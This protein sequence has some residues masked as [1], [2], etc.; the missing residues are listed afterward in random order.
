MGVKEEVYYYGNRLAVDIPPAILPDE[1][2]VP[3][4]TRMLYP[5]ILERYTYVYGG[6]GPTPEESVGAAISAAAHRRYRVGVWVPRRWVE[7]YGFPTDLKLIRIYNPV[8]NEWIDV[9]ERP[10][11]TLVPYGEGRWRTEIPIDIVRKYNMYAFPTRH[12]DYPEYAM[13][14]QLQWT[15]YTRVLIPKKPV[16]YHFHRHYEPE[17]NREK[18]RWTWI[19][20]DDVANDE[21]LYIAMEMAGSPEAARRLSS[22]RPDAEMHY[23]NGVVELQFLIPRAWDKSVASRLGKAYR[24]MVVRNYTLREEVKMEEEVTY[25][26]LIEIRATLI[27]TPPRE[28]YQG[29]GRH[30]PLVSESDMAALNI[31]CYNILRYFFLQ[32]AEVKGHFYN[33]LLSPEFRGKVE[34]TV[35]VENNKEVDFGE[36]EKERFGYVIKYI[37]IVNKSSKRRGKDWIY[38]TA[39]IDERLKRMGAIVDANG[40]VW[41]GL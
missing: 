40:F 25:N 12:P 33:P 17:W 4:P 5:R 16:I 32:T 28:F 14:V 21:G 2:K 39:E 20:P 36:V 30:M 22:P 29:H 1:Y 18:K 26:F 31:T 13:K 34:E 10:S 3:K 35:G 19:I 38:T 6:R 9:T 37:R 11:L 41:R 15:S 7:E 8:R 24:N 23:E 27:T